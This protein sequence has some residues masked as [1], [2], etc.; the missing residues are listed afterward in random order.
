MALK[1]KNSTRAVWLRAA[2]LTVSYLGSAAAFAQDCAAVQNDPYNRLSLG[3][4]GATPDWE[5]LRTAATRDTSCAIDVTA[6]YADCEYTDASG[7]HSLAF[8]NEITRIE[9]RDA[10]HR[11][12][13]LPFGLSSADSMD[14]AA[15]RLRAHFGSVVANLGALPDQNGY[16]WIT[17]GYCIRNS[18]GALVSTYVVF[19]SERRLK[20]IGSRLDW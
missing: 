13:P 18:S 14:A 17:A 2:L 11:L 3:G 16:I 12:G 1:K 7:R 6:A 10:K 15:A 9:I 19:D 20:A 5:L 8:G 4:V